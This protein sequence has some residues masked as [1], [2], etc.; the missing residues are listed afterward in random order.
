MD[1]INKLKIIRTNANQYGYKKY[2]KH[3]Y[4]IQAKNNKNKC[5]SIKHVTSNKY[6]HALL[7]TILHREYNSTIFG[8]VKRVS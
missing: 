7:W 8:S 4:F 1:I 5:Q 6:M 3:T 2:I